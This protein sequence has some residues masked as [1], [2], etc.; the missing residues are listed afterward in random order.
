MRKEVEKMK[1]Y[2]LI[3]LVLLVILMLPASAV[4]MKNVTIY[5]EFEYEG[6]MVNKTIYQFIDGMSAPYIPC[7]LPNNTTANLIF[8]FEL[9]HTGTIPDT[10]TI[11]IV[12][13]PPMP[14]VEFYFGLADIGSYYRTNLTAMATWDLTSKAIKNTTAPSYLVVTEV[15]EQNYTQLVGPQ[16]FKL[17]IT[18]VKTPNKGGYFVTAINL[19]DYYQTVEY[20]EYTAKICVAE[21]V[22]IPPPNPQVLPCEGVCYYNY[23]STTN[24]VMQAVPDSCFY[25]KAPYQEGR[26][27]LYFKKFI[28]MPGEDGV[29][30]W[31]WVEQVTPQVK[32]TNVCLEP[33]NIEV[34]SLEGRELYY[35]FDIDSYSWTGDGQWKYGEPTILG[36]PNACP[37]TYYYTGKPL[38]S[39]NVW[40]FNLTGRYLDRPGNLTSPP[41]ALRCNNSSINVYF[42]YT[43]NLAGNDK[44][45]FEAYYG[46]QWNTIKEFTIDDNTCLDKFEYTISDT[47]AAGNIQFRFRFVNDTNP[48][49]GYGF[50]VYE[51]YLVSGNTCY[52]PG[53]AKYKPDY[54]YTDCECLGDYTKIDLN[55]KYEVTV[56]AVYYDPVADATFSS[57]PKKNLTIIID[58]TGPTFSA[59]QD[60]GTSLVFSITDNLVGVEA[61]AD[62]EPIKVKYKDVGFQFSR[63]NTYP[64]YD[65]DIRYYYDLYD[66]LKQTRSV[67]VHFD[68]IELGYQDYLS[69][70]GGCRDCDIFEYNPGD[71]GGNC[72]YGLYTDWDEYYWNGCP[73]SMWVRVPLQNCEMDCSAS[74]NCEGCY[75]M[76]ECDDCAKIRFYDNLGSSQFGI[77]IDMLVYGTGIAVLKNGVDITDQCTIASDGFNATVT[78]PKNILAV[79]DEVVVVATDKVGNANYLK[80]I[81]S[82]V[83][84]TPPP[85]TPPPQEP[86]QAY[87]SN[88][89]GKI[90]DQEL[91]AAILDWLGNELSDQEL[92]NVILKWLSG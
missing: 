20:G 52:I 48:S 23:N 83:P 72:R 37:D 76:E 42:M 53:C 5:A 63:W 30:R 88:G 10:Y 24:T 92:I 58:N 85:T 28:K 18:N 56:E 8:E 64:P 66:P 51:F 41:I 46:G 50:Y 67:A 7:T 3:G 81:V 65:R 71:W 87:D 84:S 33:G 38:S 55:Y 35:Y 15:N 1:G 57:Y 75:Y 14:G 74:A 36:A 16:K 44:V 47:G 13:Q 73:H 82:G 61:N 40:G 54:Y 27:L 91:I 29:S 69:I 9:N 31:V 4:P 62:S 2:G 34:P 89:N 80:Y 90:E 25:L 11:R 77:S 39:M 70:I 49:N 17:N 22:V 68:R 32:N 43:S 78:V 45:V 60:T 26:E 59:M 79:G 86:W 6:Q 21:H 19:M 12:P